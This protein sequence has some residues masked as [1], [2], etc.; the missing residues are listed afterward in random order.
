MNINEL[1]YSTSPSFLFQLSQKIAQLFV[2]IEI[3][4][5]IFDFLE[6]MNE[7]LKVIKITS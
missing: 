6:K 1:I 4:C 2:I 7:R 5:L 3:T